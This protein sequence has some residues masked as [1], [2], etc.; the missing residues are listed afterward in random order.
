MGLV[1]HPRGPGARKQKRQGVFSARCIKP[2]PPTPSPI[3]G[4]FQG[5]LLPSSA[6][7]ARACLRPGGGACPSPHPDSGGGGGATH[8]VCLG[9]PTGGPH[10][11]SYRWGGSGCEGRGLSR[12][13]GPRGHPGEPFSGGTGRESKGGRLRGTAGGPRAAPV[14]RTAAAGKDLGGS[15]A[16]VG[17][18][19]A[20]RSRRRSSSCSFSACVRLRWARARPRWK[21]GRKASR[22]C[23]PSSSCSI[24]SW[25]GR[26]GKAWEGHDHRL[27]TGP[28]SFPP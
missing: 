24:C 1:H 3:S 25:A 2:C 19:W 23:S 8:Q 28:H 4:L 21:A 14:G 18:G 26:E 22:L 6:S 7:R 5:T 9:P 17:A 20:E 27:G 13:A 11:G 10:R 16:E 12:G 15:A